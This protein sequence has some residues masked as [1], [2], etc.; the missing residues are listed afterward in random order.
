VSNWPELDWAGWRETQQHLHLMTQIAGKI[1]LACA[2]WRNHGWH[3]TLHPTARG[4]TTGPIPVKGT[5]LQLDF[6]L[7]GNRL[8]L[9]T[10]AGGTRAIA[11][12]PGTLAGFHAEVAAALAALDAPARITPMPSEFPDPVPFPEDLRERPWD[13]DA[14]HRFH[15]ALLS[16]TRVFER[17]RTGFLGKAS[18]VHFFWGAFDLAAT[19]FSGRTAPRHPGGFPGLPDAV[20]CEAYSHEEAS[21]GFWPG[22]DAFPKPIFYAYAYPAPPGYAEAPVAPPAVFDAVLGEFVLDYD[23]VRT[24]RDPDAALLGFLQSTYTAAAD[25]GGW[26][27]GALE[28]PLGEPGRPR[29]I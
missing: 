6:D 9:A 26:D 27:R 28:C 1:L 25:L 18:P 11:L 17:F 10:S 14:V 19:R 22:S 8:D 29:K 4:L 2:P 7:I 3:I 21:A 24:A 5:T 20:T 12:R 15:R 16:S 23:A 13:I